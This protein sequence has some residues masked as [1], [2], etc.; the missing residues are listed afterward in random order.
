MKL[1]QEMG[2]HLPILAYPAT[3][4][5]PA[6]KKQAG[7]C[8]GQATYIHNI[9]H[10]GDEGGIGCDITPSPQAKTVIIVSLTH[11]RIPNDHQLASEII[12][13]QQ[14]RRAHLFEK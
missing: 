10:L 9:I 1:M 11:L 12:A 8:E 2:K 7:L 6:L 14:H 4:V 13:Y 5:P 3:D